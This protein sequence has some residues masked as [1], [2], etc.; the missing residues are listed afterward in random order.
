MARTTTGD[1]PMRPVLR[2]PYGL[3]RALLRCDRREDAAAALRR[4]L[5]LDPADPLGVGGRL[6]ASRQGRP[7]FSQKATDVAANL[8]GTTQQTDH[9]I[10]VHEIV[11]HAIAGCVGDHAETC[12][13]NVENRYRTEQGMTSRDLQRD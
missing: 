13:K 9:T 8:G 12:A 4:L 5:R 1:G 7:G 3:S 2:C 6:A 10:V 11:E